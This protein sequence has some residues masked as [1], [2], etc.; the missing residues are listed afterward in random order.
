VVSPHRA[1]HVVAPPASL[2]LYLANSSLL[3]AIA[4]VDIDPH[5]VASLPLVSVNNRAVAMFAMTSTNMVF[6]RPSGDPTAT[7]G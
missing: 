7:T 4:L 5:N 3:E 1:V 6:C 2:P